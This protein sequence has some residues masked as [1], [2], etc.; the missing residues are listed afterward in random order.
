[1]DIRNRSPKRKRK[2]V[3]MESSRPIGG[4]ESAFG[5]LKHKG[6]RRLSVKE[7]GKIAAEGWAGK[8]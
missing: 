4:I 1:M 7:I 2:V 6:K 5:V 3:A 8:R